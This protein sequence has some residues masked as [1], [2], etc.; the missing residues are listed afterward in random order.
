[1][2]AARL[3]HRLETSLRPRQVFFRTFGITG[4]KSNKPAFHSQPS[5]KSQIT[6]FRG[7]NHREGVVD[8]F[9]KMRIAEPTP[10]D[11]T[12]HGFLALRE[13]HV[14]NVQ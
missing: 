14:H 9:L 12:E 11:K 5:F 3:G 7:T 1:M 6:C 4:F 8:G 2:I 10:P 13:M